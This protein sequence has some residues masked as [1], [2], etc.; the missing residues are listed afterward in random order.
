MNL[1]RRAND[2]S[3]QKGQ[4]M[5]EYALV[6]ILVAFASIVI[7]TVLSGDAGE[8]F[9]SIACTVRGDED[10]D[11]G[12]TCSGEQLVFSDPNAAFGCLT[13]TSFVLA[14][15]TTCAN[16][17]LSLTSYGNL[18]YDTNLELYGIF[19]NP[20]SGG[21]CIGRSAGGLAPLGTY[22]VVSTHPDGNTKTHTIP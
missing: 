16:A 5:A 9:A 6:I 19:V 21:E 20:A 15:D 11:I 22:T 2:S 7:L 4:G 1:N 13:E 12:G 14:V 17:Q 18:A 3:M 8:M 10:C